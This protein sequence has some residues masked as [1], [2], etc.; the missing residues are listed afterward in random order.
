MATFTIGITGSSV[1]NGSK[2]WTLSDA[3]VQKL[4]DYQMAI[5]PGA[6]PTPQQALVMWAQTFVDKTIQDVKNHQKANLAVAP[7]AF[8]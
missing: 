6:N 1:V 7:I 4:V 8:G 2:S 5:Y 3:D